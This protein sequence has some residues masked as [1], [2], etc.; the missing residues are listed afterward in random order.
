[1][2]RSI[3]FESEQVAR[4][5]LALSVVCPPWAIMLLP[6]R[7][8]VLASGAFL[9]LLGAGVV[10]YLSNIG[11]WF[12]QYAMY[13]GSYS[14]IAFYPLQKRFSEKLILTY[15]ALLLL[16]WLISMGLAL[17]VPFVLKGVAVLL[18]GLIAWS[19][20]WLDFRGD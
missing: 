17:T 10:M 12:Y 7:H 19:F 8:R 16:V 11:N 18:L 2:I 5:F 13:T 15:K 14:L 1:M 4:K 6:K 9:L 3:Y 20:L